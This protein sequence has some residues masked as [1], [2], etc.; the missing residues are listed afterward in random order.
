[1]I[2]FS[3]GKRIKDFSKVRIYSFVHSLTHN[4]GG[5]AQGQEFQVEIK[6]LYY[7]NGNVKLETNNRNG[8]LDGIANYYYES[9]N[10]KAR[11]FYRDN[12]I[13]GLSKWYYESGEIKSERYYKDGTLVS[14]KDYDKNGRPLEA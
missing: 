1:M 2:F 6:R 7:P 12:S 8:K 5:E 13:H 4:E 14:K 10:L 9:G 3:I 11:E